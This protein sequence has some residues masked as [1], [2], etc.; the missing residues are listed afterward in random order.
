MLDLKF[1]E[2]L[3]RLIQLRKQNNLNFFVQ[4]LPQSEI[5]SNLSN[6]NETY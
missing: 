5:I 3:I 1:L 6:V 2:K 4:K